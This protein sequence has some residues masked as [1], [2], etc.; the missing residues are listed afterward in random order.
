ELQRVVKNDGVVVTVTPA[1]RHLYQLR[2]RIYQEVRLHNEEPE[3]I[4]GFELEHQQH[5]NYVMDLK[6]G[7]AIDL[8]QMTP[9]AWKA[10]DALR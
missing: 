9:F 2:E 7:A 6:N 3:H 8:L 4:E 10:T 5:L 1:S